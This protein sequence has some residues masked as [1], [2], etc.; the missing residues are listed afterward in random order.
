[1]ARVLSSDFKT[2]TNVITTYALDL[3][4]IPKG[5]SVQY[6]KGNQSN[7]ISA[8]LD[9]VRYSENGDREVVRGFDFLP[10]FT[11]KIGQAQQYR[12]LTA[13]YKVLTAMIRVNNEEHGWPKP[14]IETHP[15]IG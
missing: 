6:W 9:V 14:V 7:G 13:T 2:I 15:S 5:T 12:E 8:T 10:T 11:Y 4:L 3:G 1:M